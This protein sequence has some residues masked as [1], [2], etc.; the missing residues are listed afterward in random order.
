MWCL[1]AA[2]ALGARQAMV[3]RK[4]TE[5][6]NESRLDI[7][8][9]VNTSHLRSQNHSSSLATSIASSNLCFHH[10]DPQDIARHRKTHGLSVASLKALH[11]VVFGVGIG[12][13]RRARSC[14]RS[15]SFGKHKRI[16]ICQFLDPEGLK[17]N[18]T[19]FEK[20]QSTLSAGVVEVPMVPLPF[21]STIPLGHYVQMGR[22]QQGKTNQNWTRWNTY[23]Q[24]KAVD[25]TLISFDFYFT[26]FT[27]DL[28]F[29]PSASLADD[30]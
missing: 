7:W 30:L 17:I 19:G 1:C 22:L 18:L 25:F 4:S 28:I 24:I 20:T 26:Y 8:T 3:L 13:L 21:H 14:R 12:N 16:K 27:I 29:Q 15:N 9:P 11:V 5:W 2:L 10:K 23:E 6:Q